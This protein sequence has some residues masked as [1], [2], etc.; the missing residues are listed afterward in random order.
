ML[1]RSK[2]FSDFDFGWYVKNMFIIFQCIV[3]FGLCEIFVYYLY[4][5]FKVFLKSFLLDY[6]YLQNYENCLNKVIFYK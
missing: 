4:L 2:I 5:F 6:L 1:V 3:F